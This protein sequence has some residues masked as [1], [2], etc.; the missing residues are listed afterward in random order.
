MKIM[1]INNTYMEL[2]GSE[3]YLFDIC[4]GLE[5]R[6]HEIVIVSSSDFR[7]ITTGGRKEYFISPSGGYRS[8]K[9]SIEELRRIIEEE[10]PDILHIHNTHW[11]LSP[12]IT[13]WLT[14]LCPT[15]RFVHDVRLFCLIEK[16]L[17]RNG[18]RVCDYP[19]GVNCFI[20]RCFRH[21]FELDCYPKRTAY[22]FWRWIGRTFLELRAAKCIHAIMVGSDYMKRALVGNGFKEDKILVAPL[23]VT[24]PPAESELYQKKK[25]LIL[26]V[27]RFDRAKGAEEL[28]QALNLLKEDSWEAVMIGDGKY[29]GDGIDL[30]ESLGL[31]ERITL[32]KRISKEAVFRCHREAMVTVIPSMIPES[33]GYVGIEAFANGTP[34]IAFDAGGVTQWMRDG[35]N[36]FLLKRG[37]ISGLAARIKFLLNHPSEALE[38]GKKGRSSVEEVFTEDQHLSRIEIAYERAKERFQRERGSRKSEICQEK[39]AVN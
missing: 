15:V 8:G 10:K 29:R 11:F 22:H 14:G 3:K 28:I 35:E 23:F 21:G 30:I 9:T 32:K 26:Y 38:M 17:I 39:M 13:K 4:S 37:D 16:K 27:G 33:F 1:H 19:L 20:R 2:G 6:G 34:V 5:N 12:F 31:T 24:D 7:H 18:D 25:K 36:G